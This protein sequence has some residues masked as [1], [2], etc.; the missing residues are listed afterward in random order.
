MP[1]INIQNLEIQGNAT[2]NLS[3]RS[4][5]T[6]QVSM[7]RRK[8]DS[9]GG[10]LTKTDFFNLEKKKVSNTNTSDV[11]YSNTKGIYMKFKRK[12]VIKNNQ[13]LKNNPNLK[14]MV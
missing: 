5:K 7:G 6:V 14:L 1:E 8:S 10:S 4:A 2:F 9:Y 12:L 13:N 3:Q 11:I